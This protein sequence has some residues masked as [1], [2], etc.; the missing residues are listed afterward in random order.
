[1]VIKAVA[2]DLGH[3]LIDEEK[4]ATIRHEERPVHLMPWVSEI[5]PQI[6]NPMAVWANTQ[7]ATGAELRSFF[8]RGGI[9][10]FFAWVVT[11]VDA[12]FRKPT[13]QFFD[14]ALRT[15]EL[16]RQEVLFIGNQLNTDIAGGEGYGIRT[17]WV[18]GSAHRSADETQTP[19][20]VHPTH[21]IPTLRELPPLLRRL[22][23][24]K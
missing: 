7:T 13:P 15:C 6:P 4:D 11:S 1:M 12:G 10:R 22:R 14:F 17:V 23:H 3:T 18:S 5:L 2:F 16:A 24:A 21:T 9:G 19:T 8:D 20:D